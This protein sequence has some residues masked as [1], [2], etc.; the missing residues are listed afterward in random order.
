[1]ADHNLNFYQQLAQDYHLIFQDWTQSIMRQGIALDRLL[2]AYG[3][4]PPV[5]VLDCAAGIGTQAIGLAAR[6]YTV[7]ATDISP[8]A[9]ERAAQEAAALGVTLTTGIADMRNLKNQVA[10]DFDLVIACDNAVPHLLTDAD[11]ALAM[12]NMRAKLRPA[13]LLL[14][15]IRDYDHLLLNKPRATLPQVIDDPAPESSTTDAAKRRI[16]FQVW[17]WA[18]DRYT[19]TMF[20]LQQQDQSSDAALATPDAWRTSTYRGT[21]RA[22]QRAD[23][24]AAL[25]QA[26]FT[27]LRWHMPQDTGYHQP[28][29][30]ARG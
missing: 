7:H 5:A 14:I 15:S 25:T 18:A 19:L 20:I 4:A 23:L 26:G 13:G 21:Y 17:D 12:E 24:N 16:V 2:R 3:I 8:A 9:V 28:L 27:D 6:G 11:L 1:M 29:V 10:G 30:T 22:L